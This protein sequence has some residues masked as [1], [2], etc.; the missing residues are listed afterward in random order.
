M[1]AE[2][3]D[4]VLFDNMSPDEMAEG[5]KMIGGKMPTEASGGIDTESVKA[6][7][8]RGVDMISSG[9]LTHSSAILDL[10]LDI[11]LG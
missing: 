3:A 1:I 9:G 7:A 5:V 4:V 11:E 6:V 10:R 8:E 2:G